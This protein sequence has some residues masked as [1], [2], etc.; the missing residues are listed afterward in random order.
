M[1][2]CHLNH[3]H[4]GAVRFNFASDCILC[5]CDVRDNGDTPF[6]GDEETSIITNY[7]LGDSISSIFFSQHQTKSVE[8]LEDIDG[9]S[10]IG[11]EGCIAPSSESN[12]SDSR[13]QSKKRQVSFISFETEV[14]SESSSDEEYEVGK[15]KN[16]KKR[17]R[18]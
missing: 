7:C 16:L 3:N 10:A 5:H 6:S 4:F 1:E 8:V 13:F 17:R 9:E 15:S 14:I 11:Q 18:K 12:Y 2:D